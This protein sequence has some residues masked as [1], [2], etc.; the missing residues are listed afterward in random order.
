MEC[1]ADT[2]VVATWESGTGVER[3]QDCPVFQEKLEM[4]HLRGNLGGSNAGTSLNLWRSLS[5]KPNR[6]G[7]ESAFRNQ[8]LTAGSTYVDK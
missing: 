2:E 7:P 6:T 1:A 3:G 8:L 5:A 4:W